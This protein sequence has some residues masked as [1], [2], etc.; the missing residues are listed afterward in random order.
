[1]SR[2]A[3]RLPPAGGDVCECLVRLRG[4]EIGARL[5]ELL[6]ELGCVDQRQN[7]AFLHMRADVFIP[8]L[9]VPARAREDGSGVEGVDV[10]R[11]HELGWARRGARRDDRH[12]GNRLLLG[13]AGDLLD[14]FGAI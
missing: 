2:F 3:E 6:I 1:M 8:F 11:Q 4:D 12:G 7:L 10:P 14:T 9:H 5:S 13:P